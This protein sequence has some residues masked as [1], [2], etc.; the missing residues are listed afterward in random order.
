MNSKS[1]EGK[2]AVITG[3]NS[4][5]GLATA[6]LMLD[7]GA[8][9]IITGRD[10]VKLLAAAQQLG[11]RTTAVVCDATDPEA[12][13]ELG[14]TVASAVGKVDILFANAGITGATPMGSADWATFEV[15]LK[16]NL[17]AVFFT[18][19]A[20]LDRLNDGASI[21]LNSSVIRGVGAPTTAAY[22]ASKAGVSAMVKVLASELAHR[23]IRVNAV[24]P[25][26]TASP[27]WTRDREAGADLTAT[28]RFFAGRTLTGRFNDVDDIA[29][30]V[31]FL[32]SPLSASMTAAE[33]VVDGG[34]LGA[35]WGYQALRSS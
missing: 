29:Q 26:A 11:E 31:L 19:Q 18:I 13:H 25:G 20:L 22:A 14:N 27:I 28:E 4:G 1:L 16:T 21:V 15:V 3:G 24:V 34:C 23:R 30:A 32:A 2:M 33:I 6:R 5:I 17:T 12:L 10:K 35:P 8:N 7:A 9:V